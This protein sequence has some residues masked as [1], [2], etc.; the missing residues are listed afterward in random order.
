M[1][2]AGMQLRIQICVAGLEVRLNFVSP[3][4]LCPEI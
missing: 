2:V 1:A 4:Q 3:S